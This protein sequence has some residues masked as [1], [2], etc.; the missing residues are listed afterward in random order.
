MEGVFF[1][2]VPMK[3]AQ[4]NYLYKVG[5]MQWSLIYETPKAIATKVL[6]FCGVGVIRMGS[7]VTFGI[8][9]HIRLWQ[10]S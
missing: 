2:V 8:I 3:L 5:I 4:D 7:S 1:V 9:N 10:A 6:H